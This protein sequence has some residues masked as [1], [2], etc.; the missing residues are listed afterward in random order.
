MT[1][2][3]LK[4]NDVCARKELRR[5]RKIEISRKNDKVLPQKVYMNWA[6]L[7]D[8]IILRNR[9]FIPWKKARKT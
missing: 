1:N 7:T 4:G 9:I 2:L 3:T 5:I 8:R 6:I